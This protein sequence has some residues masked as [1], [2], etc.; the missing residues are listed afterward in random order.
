MPKDLLYV[1]S[2]LD[3]KWKIS[4][5]DGKRV[6]FL[7]ERGSFHSPKWFG[8]Q[9]LFNSFV[10]VYLIKERL[11]FFCHRFMVWRASD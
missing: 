3:T 11:K 10:A 2:S 6:L 7:Q 1:I 4:P 5:I 8:F 9:E